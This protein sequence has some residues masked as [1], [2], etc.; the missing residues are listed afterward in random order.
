MPVDEI[1]ASH[2]RGPLSPTNAGPELL[3]DSAS[4]NLDE[5]IFSDG[6]LDLL[7][8]NSLVGDF[9]PDTFLVP[10]IQ[11]FKDRVLLGSFYVVSHLDSYVP[12]DA[13]IIIQKQNPK[14]GPHGSAVARAYCISTLKSYPGM[15]CA[16]DRMLPPFIH[17]PCPPHHQLKS[18]GPHQN[19]TASLPESLAICSSIIQMY[20]AQTPGNLAFIWR[21][22]QMEVLRMDQEV[23]P[24]P[25]KVMN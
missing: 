23:G 5:T 22:I 10:P 17:S 16:S 18:L 3:S 21:T 7:C 2:D 12:F 25:P 6:F 19:L 1:A 20:T 4:N 9:Q 24:S 11:Y 13:N 14:A 15:M 8:P